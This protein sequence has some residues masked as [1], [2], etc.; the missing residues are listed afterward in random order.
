MNRGASLRLCGVL[1]IWHLAGCDERPAGADATADHRPPD[2]HAATGDLTPPPDAAQDT[3]TPPVDAG[4]DG[5]VPRDRADATQDAPTDDGAF[6]AALD[7]RDAS[8]DDGAPDATPDVRGDRPAPIDGPVE[9]IDATTPDEGAVAFDVDDA[10][11][12]PRAGGPF[13]A[14]P[15]CTP[16]RTQPCLCSGGRRGAALCTPD[17]LW[18]YCVCTS[19]DAGVGVVDGR[20]TVVERPIPWIGRPRLIAPQSG[21]RVTSQRPTLRWLL[22]SG[23]E[24]ARVELCADRPCAR[25]LA[26]Q[27][28][29]GDR[30]RPTAALP[31]GVV[32][33]RVRG[34]D[35]AGAARWTSATWEFG[36]R[37]RDLGV[38]TSYGPLKDFNGD[39]YDDYVTSDTFTTMLI[40]PGSARGIEVSRV[41]EL[42]IVPVRPLDAVGLVTPP[43]IGDFNGDGLAD[44]VF[45]SDLYH[46]A[47]VHLGS[48]TCVLAR[49]GMRYS[50]TFHPSGRVEEAAM[51]AGDFNGDGYADF[52]SNSFRTQ[53]YLGGPA[54]PAEVP[55]DISTLTSAVAAFV[56]DLNGDGYQDILSGVT[57]SGPYRSAIPLILLYGN[58]EGRLDFHVELLPDPRHGRLSDFL[59]T[60]FGFRIRWGDLNEDGYMDA[61]VSAPGELFAY[62]GSPA[63]YGRLVELSTTDLSFGNGETNGFGAYTPH[64]IDLDGD[65][66]ADLLT[67]HPGTPADPVTER[68]GPGRL[69]VFGRDPAT[70][71]AQ[72]TPTLIVDA[73]VGSGAFGRLA[74]PGDLNGDGY[75]DIAAGAVRT[76]LGEPYTGR[77]HVY[78]GGSTD[79]WRRP[80]TTIDRPACCLSGE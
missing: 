73:P 26:Q 1:C 49:T 14:G 17:G 70:G 19:T 9:G 31:A 51:S 7:A 25:V 8:V 27:E 62:Y 29:R 43:G 57:D 41:V 54:G 59:Q 6:D 11:T 32:F 16:G 77:V 13:D 36:V 58:P 75:D 69:Y 24:R 46:R 63:G 34:L 67:S 52:I 42:P 28:V 66:R 79:W 56:G 4:P 33:W 45:G 50:A 38:D 64:P 61:L 74:T 22:P 55:S 15:A 71:F 72:T 35:A 10:C 21:M 53:L 20:V 76:S 80:V 39:G 60:L 47:Y 30:W 40:Y 5:D 2:D 78:H 68:N 37:H 3:A 48:R 12:V 18:D 65:G 44:L 23:L